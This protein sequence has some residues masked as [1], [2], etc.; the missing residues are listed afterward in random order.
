MK[1][2]LLFFV[3]SAIVLVGI[4]AF[5]VKSDGEKDEILIQSILSGMQQLHYAPLEIDDAYSERVYDLY[6]D[7]LDGSKRFFTVDD[8]AQ[9]KKYKTEI[10]DQVS[11]S[12]FQF[13]DL[14]VE[15]LKKRTVQIESYYKEMLAE[16]FEFTKEETIEFDEE[17]LDHAKDETEL[18]DRWRKALK[19]RVLDRIVEN[20]EKQEKAKEEAAKEKEVNVKGL[21][22]KA[23]EFEKIKE[24]SKK[25]KDEKDVLDMT[26]EELEVKARKDEMKTHDRWFEQLAKQE[27]RDYIATYLNAVTS[28]FDPHTNYFAP[29]EKETFDISI[30]GRLEGIGAQLREVDGDIKVIRIVPGSASWR[31]K[32]LEANDVI[33]KVAQGEEEP[34][35]VV[36]MRLDDAVKLIRGKKGTE[37]RLTVKKVG[38]DTK[39]I[40]ITR[41]IVILEESYA[42]S[43]IIESDKAAGKIGLIYLPKFYADF[44]K[45]GGRNCAEDI[46]KELEGLKEENVSGIILDL[47][48]NGGGSLNEVVDMSGLFIEKGPIVQVKSKGDAPKVLRDK[49]SKTTY[50]GPLVVMVNSG[51]ASASEILAAALQDY[52]RAVII[53]GN[54]TF[55]KGTVQRFINL[56]RTIPATLS[57]VRPLGSVKMTVQKF[58]RI[59]GGATQL[60]GVE[61]DIILPSRYN[62]IEMGEKEHDFPMVWDE[63]EPVEYEACTSIKSLAKIKQRSQ[64]RVKSNET[65]SMIDERAKLLKEERDNPNNQLSLK[66]Y[67]AAEDASE[68]RFKKY[69]ELMKEEIPGI[70]VSQPEFFVQTVE[71]DSAQIARLDEWHKSIRKDIYLDEALQVLND[72]INQ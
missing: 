4:W 50:D 60:K 9:L 19:Y 32:D 31:Q 35:D 46:R 13:F 17:K 38:G 3:L 29:A 6:L 40:P 27:H 42:K 16:P 55:G 25:D 67:R 22:G 39:I 8:I 33:I 52:E 61:P 2:S 23:K 51:S 7:D 41:D 57:G 70:K 37:V 58:Y 53:G 72:L 64:N 1:K 34:V 26:F 47:R 54:S 49:N 30:S 15:L 28:A 62:Y 11:A 59:D 14:S 68:A 44:T 48:N 69:E 5:Q 66:K 71:P 45:T 10:D 12:E 36:G 63:I 21:A 18:R 65:F 56:D 20:L 43:S 24:E